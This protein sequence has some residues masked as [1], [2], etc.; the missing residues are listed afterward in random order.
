MNDNRT[1]EE[2]LEEIM[3]SVIHNNPDTDRFALAQ[4]FI[5]AVETFMP[6][7]IDRDTVELGTEE[8]D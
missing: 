2:R 1:R 4:A 7:E 5:V 3:R 8:R 6:E